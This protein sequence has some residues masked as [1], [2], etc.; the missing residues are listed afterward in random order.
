[1]AIQA[2]RFSLT[3]TLSGREKEQQ[4]HVRF[5]FQDVRPNSAIRFSAGDGLRFSFLQRERASVMENSWKT[6]AS[7]SA[8]NL[9]P[10]IR[11]T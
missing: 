9:Q 2:G 1:M 6:R 11:F 3:L 5:S 10:Q 4:L 8:R 7:E